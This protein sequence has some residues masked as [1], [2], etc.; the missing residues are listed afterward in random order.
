MIKIVVD[1][2]IVFSAILNT[3]SNIA[4]V[5]LKPDSNFSFYSTSQ[6]HTEIENHRSKIKKLSGYSDGELN[7]IIELVY[8]RIKFIDIGLIPKENYRMAVELT[9]NIDIDDTEFVALAEFIKGKFWSGD[10]KLISGL[11]K[12][13]WGLLISLKE[14]LNQK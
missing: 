4:N 13:G 11:T 10:K 9:S 14:L 8:Q 2:N 7:R 5:L 1:T 6:L 3:N 12:K